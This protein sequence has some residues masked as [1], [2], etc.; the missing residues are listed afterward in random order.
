LA[1][2]RLLSKNVFALGPNFELVIVDA[3]SP[4][5][6][7]GQKVPPTLHIYILLYGWELNRCTH[8]AWGCAAHWMD[9]EIEYSWRWWERAGA[10]VWWER[11]GWGSEEN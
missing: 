11:E 2:P 10:A 9:T 3:K 8:I 1:D 7:M 4:S 6:R 5:L